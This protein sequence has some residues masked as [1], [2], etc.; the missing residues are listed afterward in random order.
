MDFI[1]PAWYSD[2]LLSLHRGGDTSSVELFAHEKAKAK[3]IFAKA[4]PTQAIFNC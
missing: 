1:C 2:T 4:I 3:A